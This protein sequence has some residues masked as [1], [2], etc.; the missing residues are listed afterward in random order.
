MDF[1]PVIVRP[2]VSKRSG[3]VITVQFIGMALLAFTEGAGTAAVLVPAGRRHR[4]EQ[5]GTAVA[6][7]S[8][9]SRLVSGIERLA[10]EEVVLTA[11]L[12]SVHMSSR[13]RLIRRSLL[14]VREAFRARS[15]RVKED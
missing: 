12:T 11:Q 4:L 2:S 9:A 13:R 5:F 3:R 8:T 14:S 15:S 10:Y 1:C 6:N 7:R